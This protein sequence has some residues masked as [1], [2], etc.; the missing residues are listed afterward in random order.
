MTPKEK[1]KD[2]FFALVKEYRISERWVEH[3]EELFDE[4]EELIKSLK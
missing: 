3:F 2:S 1:L 4:I